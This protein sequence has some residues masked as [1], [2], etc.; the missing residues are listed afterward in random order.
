VA[1][2]PLSRGDLKNLVDI[3]GVEQADQIDS[4]LCRLSS[5]M[6]EGKPDGLLRLKHLSFPEFLNDAGRC[7]DRRFVVDHHEL[8]RRL[9]L[10]CLR[11]MNRELRFNIYNLKT[12]HLRTAMTMS[13]LLHLTLSSLSR[14]IYHIRV[15]SGRI[16]S[17]IRP[18]RKFTTMLV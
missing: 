9:A 18:S 17:D 8:H 10:A 2:V 7:R 14:L 13:R 1:K 3:Q 11:L 12:S 6:S 4:V 15:V 16:I 5:V